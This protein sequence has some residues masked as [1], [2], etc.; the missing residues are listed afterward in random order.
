[1]KILCV[2]YDDPKTGMPK[3]YPVSTLPKLDNKEI[4]KSE[5]FLNSLKH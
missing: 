2:L 4:L 3:N 5:H 1:M